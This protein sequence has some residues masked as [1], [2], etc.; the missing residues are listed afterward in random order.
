MRG[1]SG[2]KQTVVIVDKVH[3]ALVDAL[4]VG[5]VSERR[6]DA[7]GLV[8]DFRE[9]A[10]VLDEPIVSLAGADLIS[11]QDAIL[12]FVVEGTSFGSWLVGENVYAH[13]NLP[14]PAMDY[15]AQYGT[16]LRLAVL[17]PSSPVIA[18]ARIAWRTPAMRQ[19]QR[20]EL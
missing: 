15:A 2:R 4:V 12:K 7:Y 6:M 1:R 20:K 19:Q 9:R 10:P 11:G 14:A 8:D 13:G 16:R 3:K 17:R 5:N 18:I